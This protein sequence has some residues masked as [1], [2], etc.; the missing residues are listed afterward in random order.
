MNNNFLIIFLSLVTALFLTLLPMP[1]WAIWLRPA[2]VLMMLIYW[3]IT[4]PEQV[5]V[6][7]AWICGIFLDMLE[8]TILGEHALAFVVIIYLVTRMYTR[9]RMFPILQQSFSIFLLVLLYQCI[10]FCIQGFIGSLPNSWLFWSSSV[11]SMLLWPWLLS[12]LRSKTT[13]KIV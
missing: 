6:G 7:I 2:W 3:A 10:I 12:F 8:G 1:E 4:T 13:V 9:L 11:T 5:N